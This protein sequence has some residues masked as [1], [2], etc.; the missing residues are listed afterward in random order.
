[1]EQFPKEMRDASVSCGSGCGKVRN[2]FD[3]QMRVS[4]D[5]LH[6]ATS[7][8]HSYHDTGGVSEF[9]GGSTMARV[10]QRPKLL[11]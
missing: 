6:C 8:G 7:N 1:M 5:G 11:P 3:Y 4:S 2:N 10:G 9:V